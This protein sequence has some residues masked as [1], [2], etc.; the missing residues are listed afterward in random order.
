MLARTGLGLNVLGTP[1]KRLELLVLVGVQ[2]S[3]GGVG[4]LLTGA[5]ENLV[6]AVGQSDS[7]RRTVCMCVGS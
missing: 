4:S 5:S 7:R 2:L 1:E 6:R 3:G